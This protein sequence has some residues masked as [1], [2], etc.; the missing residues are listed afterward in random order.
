MFATVI[1]TEQYNG[2]YNLTK[3][4]LRVWCAASTSLGIPNPVCIPHI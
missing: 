2:D 1:P 4:E 3:E